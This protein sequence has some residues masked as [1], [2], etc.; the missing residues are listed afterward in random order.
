MHAERWLL[1]YQNARHNTAPNPPSPAAAAA[2]F[3]DF[4]VYA[5]PA[6]DSRRIN[7]I[8]QHFIT[9]FLGLQLKGEPLQAYLDLPPLDND[10]SIRPDAGLWKGF[11]KR[12]AVGW[13]CAICRRIKTVFGELAADPAGK[14]RAQQQSEAHSSRSRS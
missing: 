4:M 9:A 8:N 6:W 5:E 2:G 13:S 14:C 12:A 3:D 11:R 7:N 10:G 1:T